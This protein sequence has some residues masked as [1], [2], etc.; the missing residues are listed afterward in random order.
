M[1]CLSLLRHMKQ[2]HRDEKEREERHTHRS[3]MAW[4]DSSCGRESCI[5]G[6]LDGQLDLAFNVRGRH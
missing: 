5:A 2:A 4:P 1:H 6:E 3:H